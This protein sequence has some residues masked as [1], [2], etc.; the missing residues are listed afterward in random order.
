MT[1]NHPRVL[2]STA[3]LAFVLA[4]GAAAETIAGT[5]LEAAGLVAD[6]PWAFEV[7]V[8]PAT[9]DAEV[10]TTRCCFKSTAPIRRTEAGAEYL[11]VDLRVLEHEN[12]G[13][14]EAAFEELLAD[15]DP[16]IGLSYA[17]DRV[18]LSGALI[19]RLHAGCL[20]SEGNFQ[21]IA[22]WLEEA[23]RRRTGSDLR[24]VACWC[25]SGCEELSAVHAPSAQ[26]K[27]GSHG[28]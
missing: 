10:R 17:W 11:R 26:H 8:E 20:F 23:V 14:A 21:R 19:Y 15:A 16:N 12:A 5:D 1:S 27:G 18:L 6:L 3:A 9:E 7:T 4:A 25:G 13:S 24:V 22:E 2:I 28:F